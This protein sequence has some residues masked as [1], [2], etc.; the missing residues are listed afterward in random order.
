MYTKAQEDAMARAR[1]VSVE[2]GEAR[3]GVLGRIMAWIRSGFWAGETSEEAQRW[4]PPSAEA[5]GPVRN[6]QDGRAREAERR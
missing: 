4:Q 5:K 6:L 1:G 3:W 2:E